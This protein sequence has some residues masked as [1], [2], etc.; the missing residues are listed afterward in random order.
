[1][2]LERLAYPLCA[3]FV[4]VAL[5]FLAAGNALGTAWFAMSVMWFTLGYT[6]RPPKS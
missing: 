6:R 5:G 3:I 1:M 2:L 4:A